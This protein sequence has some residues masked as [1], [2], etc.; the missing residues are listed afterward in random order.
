ML[1][2]LKNLDCYCP[3]HIG[4]NDVLICGD[5]I[6]K[7]KPNIEIN[8]VSLL[9][10][11]YDCDGLYGFPGIIDQ[12]VHI[13]GGGG[14]DGF[15]SRVAEID[16]NNIIN[17]GVTTLVGLLG[18]D[19][20]TRSMKS[21]YAKA[22][23][24]EIQGLTTYIYSGSYSVPPVTLTTNI[25]NDLVLI[26]KVIGIGEIA[27]ADHRSSHSSINE[28][29]KISSD[30]H[31]GGLLGNKAG[32][33]HLHVGDGKDGL[34]D[35]LQLINLSD[36]P[37]EGFVP[38]H[39]NRNNALFQQA[40]DFCNSGGNIDLTAGETAGITV[41]D[42]IRK[43]INDKIDTSK[44]TVSSDSN[45]SIPSGG[46]SN[47]KTL[48]DDIISCIVKGEIN[49]EIAFSLVTEN[50]AKILKIFPKKGTLS[51]KSDADILITDKNYEIKK[52]ISMGK[53][54]LNN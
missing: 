10:N 42:A 25:I 54:L 22:K 26:D 45:G 17:A 29:L 52:L 16:F 40:I 32:V 33:V 36:L 6:Y 48:F 18:A 24:L 1:T 44:V 51:E 5:K 21:L 23:S 11:I 15:N 19:S 46:V 9:E 53:L 13:I 43:L 41:N 14:E 4:K 49:P 12:H 50:V 34:S 8:D 39:V 30:A 27:I 2:L 38:T 31:L 20:C 35:L 7:I 47:I 28:L 37:I 3:N